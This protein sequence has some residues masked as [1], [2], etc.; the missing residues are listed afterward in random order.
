VCAHTQIIIFFLMEFTSCYRYEASARRIVHIVTGKSLRGAA[1]WSKATFCGPG[2]GRPPRQRRGT[3]AVSPPSSSRCPKLPPWVAKR[4]GM[5]LDAQVERAALS[6]R[7]TREAALQVSNHPHTRSLLLYLHQKGYAL[8]A[9]QFIVGCLRA[10]LAT[11][12]DAVALDSKGRPCLFEFKHSHPDDFGGPGIR[13]R[14][15]K[16]GR[17]NTEML[18]PF[19]DYDDTPY[20]RAQLQLAMGTALWESEGRPRPG[21]SFVA[22]VH[23]DGVQLYVLEKKMLELARS[24]LFEVAQNRSPPEEATKTKTVEDRRRRLI[25]ASADVESPKKKQRRR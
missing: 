4:M 14:D 15:R 5:T 18:A 13:R 21:P 3:T 12:L 23:L 9:S 1:S 10:R 22:R 11:P 19:Q 2:S 24:V 16:N 25:S 20:H 6:P 8:V 17:G 7:S